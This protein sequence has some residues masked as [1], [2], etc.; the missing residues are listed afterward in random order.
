MAS[1]ARYRIIRK[2]PNEVLLITL[3]SEIDPILQAL[4]NRLDEFRQ[5]RDP[6]VGDYQIQKRK[7]FWKQFLDDTPRPVRRRLPKQWAL[8]MGL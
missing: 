6:R 3:H 2:S 4:L 1:R 5:I 8:C 7:P